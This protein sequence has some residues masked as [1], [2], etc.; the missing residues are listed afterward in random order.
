MSELLNSICGP[1]TIDGVKTGWCCPHCGNTYL[2]GDKFKSYHC[3]ID[4]EKFKKALKEKSHMVIGADGV[5]GKRDIKR[6]RHDLIPL[7]FLDMLAEIFEEGF[8]KYGDSW[9]RGGEGFLV[10]C[11]NHA[12]NH[13]HK[14]C[15]GDLSEAQLAKTAWN[16]LAIA[17]HDRRGSGLDMYRE[18]GKSL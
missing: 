5:G 11:L 10:D 17:Y 6:P 12:S 14:Y 8:C 7:E 2:E 3:A 13:L 1:I 4:F 18:K 16:C 9:K 15:N